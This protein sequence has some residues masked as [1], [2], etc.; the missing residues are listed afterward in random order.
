MRD[1][2]PSPIL[3][4]VAVCA[5]ALLLSAAAGAADRGD[6]TAYDQANPP[7]ESDKSPPVTA[8]VP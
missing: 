5:G 4:A 6:K 2:Q 7:N 3:R 8:N 1:L